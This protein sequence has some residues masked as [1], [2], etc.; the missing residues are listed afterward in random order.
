MRRYGIWI[1]TLTSILAWPCFSTANEP[2]QFV[3]HSEVA[4]Q[5]GS[6]GQALYQYDQAAWHGTDAFLADLPD[7]FDNGTV[8]GYVV[9][10]HEKPKW[11]NVV[12]RSDEGVIWEARVKG[13]RVRDAR[14]LAQPRA[15]SKDEQ[16]RVDAVDTAIPEVTEACQDRL[17]M[18]TA[19]LPVPDS[20][21]LYVYVLSP[22]KDMGEAVFGRHHRIRVSG[23][24]LTL[25]NSRTFTKSCLVVSAHTDRGERVG[26]TASHLLDPFPQETHVFVSL[27]HDLPVYVAIPDTARGRAK[28]GKTHIFEVDGSKIRRVA[29]VQ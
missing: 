6:L 28:T 22:M 9:T 27:Q 14:W 13:K 24:G 5:I 12:F 8:R 19:V 26:I 16:A 1:T 15:L 29:A 7:G 20:D 4:E 18:N 21:D 11:L 3:T 25:I 2:A 17:P 10:P 23:N